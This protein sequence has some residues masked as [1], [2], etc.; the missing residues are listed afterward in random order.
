MDQYYTSVSHEGNEQ[1]LNYELSIMLGFIYIY[2][3]MMH[4]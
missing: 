4:L 3:F 1:S 2:Y